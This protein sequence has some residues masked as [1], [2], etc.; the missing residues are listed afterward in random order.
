MFRKCEHQKM[1]ATPAHLPGPDDDA[2]A[3]AWARRLERTAAARSG[4]SIDD[5]RAD[6]AR[7]I[8][9]QATPG[10]IRNLSEGRVKGVKSWLFRRLRARIIA[11]LQ[12]E[13]KALSHEL[14][15]ARLAGLDVDLGAVAEAE[16]DLGRVRAALARLALAPM[17]SGDAP[18]RS[19]EAV[20]RG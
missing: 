1:V 12:S 5:A 17:G 6:V 8:G 11:N 19:V 13:L 15:V 16:A 18:R 10:M 20:T 14:E 9:G 2:L 7:E 4:R 3:Q